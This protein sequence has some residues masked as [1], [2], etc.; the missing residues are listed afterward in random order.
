MSRDHDDSNR[1]PSLAHGQARYVVAGVPFPSKLAL[2]AYR[3]RVFP[4]ARR[5]EECRD[6]VLLEL[7]ATEPR[8]V[9]GVLPSP[10]ALSFRRAEDDGFYKCHMRC[11]GQWVSFSLNDRIDGLQRDD[12]QRFVVR[13]TRW[14]R[15]VSRAILE[16]RRQPSCAVCGGPAVDVDH[17]RPQF[18]ELN[19]QALEMV[20]AQ[21]QRSWFGW[22]TGQRV[23]F[24]PD[25]SHP[26]H[27]FVTRMAWEG[28]VQSLC[29][30]CHI[31][32]TSTRRSDA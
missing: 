20:S 8:V 6:A 21:E 14:H 4:D 23:S 9:E 24:G 31:T 26:I 11:G 7:A 16:Q 10:E 1:P 12:G 13:F 2:H 22:R 28:E 30:S 27:V 29:K 3:K 5:D 15:E 19:R 18:A 32:T 17:V 25:E